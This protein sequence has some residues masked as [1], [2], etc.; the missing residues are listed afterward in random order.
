MPVQ[1]I[2]SG[3]PLFKSAG[4]PAMDPDCCCDDTPCF[5]P[6]VFC[7]CALDDYPAGLEDATLYIT[8]PSDSSQCFYR[9]LSIFVAPCDPVPGYDF[10]GT[11]VLLCDE[12]VQSTDGKT[13][14]LADN[15]TFVCTRRNGAQ[16]QILDWYA[17]ETLSVFWR[18]PGGSL[19]GE[20]AVVIVDY[21]S[22]VVGVGV[23]NNPTVDPILVNLS[24]FGYR[25]RYLY[26]LITVQTLDACGLLQLTRY[27]C[28]TLASWFIE[29]I[30]SGGITDPGACTTAT[31]VADYAPSVLY[32]GVP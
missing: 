26:R 25:R 15:W 5:D 30:K 22:Y 14:T 16:P 10:A 7:Q 1:F 11:Y 29:Q 17:R 12:Q 28:G 2:S 13:Q 6:S 19:G 9:G 21:T 20:A 24:G 18:I 3:V 32:I 31:T 27:K 4:V 8:I 23:G